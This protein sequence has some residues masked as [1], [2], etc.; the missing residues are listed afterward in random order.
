MCL[1]SH[2]VF[3]CGIFSFHTYLLNYVGLPPNSPANATSGPGGSRQA[4]VATAVDR[5][6]G[7]EKFE[8]ELLRT[9]RNPGIDLFRLN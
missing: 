6:Q 1:G 5:G 2:H 9:Y 3:W 8:T 4:V 7:N